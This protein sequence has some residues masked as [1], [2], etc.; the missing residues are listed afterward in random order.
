MYIYI[1]IYIKWTTFT[2]IIFCGF[3]GLG[4]FLRNI[5]NPPVQSGK[6]SEK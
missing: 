1:C 2:Q 5:R 3:R 6:I 4:P